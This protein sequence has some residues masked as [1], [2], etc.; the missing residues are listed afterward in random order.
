[1]AMQEAAP[2]YKSLS[3]EEKARYIKIAEG[4]ICPPQ[5]K[6]AQQIVLISCHNF[7]GHLVVIQ[8]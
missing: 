5:Q 3:A 6:M 7:L 2:I 8:K 4:Q 1:M